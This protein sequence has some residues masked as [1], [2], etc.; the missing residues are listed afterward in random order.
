MYVCMY[1]F[2]YKCI[3]QILFPCLALYK[4]IEGMINKIRRDDNP[5]TPIAERFEM[6]PEVVE[7]I[8]EENMNQ[9]AGDIYAELI[10]Q[11][12]LMVSEA[13]ELIG[14][15]KDAASHSGAMPP[16]DMAAMEAV[17]LGVSKTT[18]VD[19]ALLPRRFRANSYT[20]AEQI[21]HMAM[22]KRR[23]IQQRARINL[24]MIIASFRRSSAQLP[25]I[26]CHCGG[27]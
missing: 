2:E 13:L 10:G 6:T 18:R 23:T 12:Q 17:Q 7:R 3:W 22:R 19:S 5:S 1:I 21:S 9:M 26:F 4:N 15:D 11:V 8:C 20:S 25:R 24:I 14:N 16:G 27:D